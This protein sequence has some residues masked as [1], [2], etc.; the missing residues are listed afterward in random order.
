[1]AQFSNGAEAEEGA[2]T[3][4]LS[5]LSFSRENRATKQKSAAELAPSDDSPGL[6]DRAVRSPGASAQLLQP[7]PSFS[8]RRGVPGATPIGMFLLRARSTVMQERCCLRGVTERA[9]VYRRM[10]HKLLGVLRVR[11]CAQIRTLAP[12]MESDTCCFNK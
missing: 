3:P 12:G 2:L 1:M 9:G 11:T 5:L 6:W 4:A 7:V 10:L 8:Q